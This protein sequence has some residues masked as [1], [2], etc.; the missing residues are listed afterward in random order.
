MREVVGRNLGEERIIQIA[1]VTRNISQLTIFSPGNGI[2]TADLLG[3]LAD[4]CPE[5][6]EFMEPWQ[7][8]WQSCDDDQAQKI[9]N[10]YAID[11]VMGTD[12]LIRTLARCVGNCESCM[13]KRDTPVSIEVANRINTFKL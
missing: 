6:P 13:F 9:D 4:R 1:Q 3:T 5:A 8:L 12:K 11:I 10:A 2:F 7:N